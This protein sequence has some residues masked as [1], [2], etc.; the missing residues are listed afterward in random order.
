VTELEKGD[1]EKLARLRDE[2]Q[3]GLDDLAAGRVSD[4]KDVFAHLKARF[5]SDRVVRSIRHPGEGRD[6][7]VR[8]K[9]G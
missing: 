8:G 4:G 2:L 5:P 1:A 6:P 9:I 7:L 3:K